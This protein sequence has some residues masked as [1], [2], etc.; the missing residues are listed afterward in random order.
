V[1]GLNELV[2][3][4]AARRVLAQNHKPTGN[5]SQKTDEPVDEHDGDRSCGTGPTATRARAIAAS[6]T[7]MEPG[8]SGTLAATWPTA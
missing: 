5:G 6:A 7:P 2:Q 1:G 8:N 4:L 3:G